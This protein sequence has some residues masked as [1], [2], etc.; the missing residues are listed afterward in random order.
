LK[1]EALLEGARQPKPYSLKNDDKTLVMM[2]YTHSALYRGEAIMKQHIKVSNWMRVQGAPEYIHLQKAQAINISSAGMAKPL[3]YSEMLV[4]T[5]SLI[6]YHIAPPSQPEAMDYDETEANR[7]FEAVTALV[8]T[9]VFSGYMRI[10]AS[11]DVSQALLTSRTPWLSLYQVE[12]S[13]PYIPQLG[14]LKI[15]LVQIRPTE[16]QFGLTTG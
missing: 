11:V 2:L 9:F 6:A 4:P 10:A 15:P 16:I 8:G 7:I 13:N 3:A 12:I 1:G 14:V 5:S